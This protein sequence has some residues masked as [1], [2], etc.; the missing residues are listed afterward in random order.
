MY[1]SLAGNSSIFKEPKVSD[2]L[3]R[4]HTLDPILSRYNPGHN[5]ITYFMNI[6]IMLLSRLTSYFYCKFLIKMCSKY[7]YSPFVHGIYL[8]LTPTQDLID[9]TATE[10]K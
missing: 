4:A 5:M 2:M 9:P 8:D 7:S 10:N 3:T 6:L 1:G